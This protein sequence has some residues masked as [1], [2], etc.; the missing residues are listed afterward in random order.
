MWFAIYQYIQAV[1]SKIAPRAEACPRS[2]AFVF[3]TH[4]SQSNVIGFTV[5]QDV[6]TLRY[7]DPANG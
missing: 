4:V 2:P 7:N 3:A 6:K 5:E 1:S